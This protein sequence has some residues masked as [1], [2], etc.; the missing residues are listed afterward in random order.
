MTVMSAGCAV[1][2]WTRRVKVHINIRVLTKRTR[3]LGT[4]RV[5]PVQKTKQN[6]ERLQPC[7]RARHG[8]HRV[9]PP[10]VPA[11]GHHPDIC[12]ADPRVTTFSAGKWWWMSLMPEASVRMAQLMRDYNSNRVTSWSDTGDKD[13]SYA[14]MFPMTVLFLWSCTANSCSI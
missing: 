14:M 2:R 12:R 11:D 9:A 6:K 13:N 3:N 5:L 10:H 8:Q 4:Y 7:S 1:S